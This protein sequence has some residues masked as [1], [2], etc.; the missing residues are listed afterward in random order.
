MMLLA[1]RLDRRLSAILAADV[2][3][4]SRL[5]GADEE[6]TLV[7]LRGHRNGV[8]EPKITEH[9]GRLVKT[10]GDGMLAEFASA[11]DAVRC[12]V[13][14]QLAT[15]SA[16]LSVASSK[17]VEFRIGVHVGDIISEDGDI[18]GD[19]VNIA[20]RLEGLA[21]PGGI[22]VS[23]RVQEDVDGRL[24]VTFR[25]G[26]EQQLKNIARP[27]RVY[28]I[29]F[30]RAET[31]AAPAPMLALPGKPSVVVLPFQN[32]SPDPDQDYF[33]D[34]MVED[35][36]M[37]LSRFS[38][39]FVISR[40][41]S[42]TYKG[43]AVDVKQI[44]REL[45]VRYVLEGSVRKAG[46]R[47]RISGQLVDAITGTH[48][49]VDRFEGT[50][51]DVFDLQDKVTSRVAG[52]LVPTIRHAEIERAKHRPTES[53]DAHMTYMRGIGSLYQW[54]KA[55]IE[56][57]LKLFHEAM[58][59]DPDFSMPY[60][61][62]AV[63]Y[64]TLR[65]TGWVGDL[66]SLVPRVHELVARA[67]EV[68]RDDAFTLGSC[69]FAAANILG[70]LDTG[71]ALLD[72]A[73]AMNVNHALMWAQSAYV[74][75]WRGEPELALAHTERARRLSP[76]DPQTFTID[77]AAALAHFIAGRDEEALAVAEMA[78]RQNPFFSPATRIA[79]ASAALLNRTE[80]TKKYLAQLKLLDPNLS[81]SNLDTRVGVR[82]PEDIARFGAG[83][84]KAGLPE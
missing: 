33:A 20:A 32:M 69:G 28:R 25:D 36:I 53:T 42:F 44:G 6:G 41:S 56:E 66:A 38:S 73:L 67:P 82:R 40:N 3:G 46:Q 24:D 37:A 70:D 51:E 84:R 61:M 54:T 34:G 72:R 2:A 11:V 19:G 58:R 80:L 76:V 26:G 45:G 60:G 17:R 47:V 68:G 27:I 16:N 57:A 7:Q 12:A 39:L 10:T 78:L 62:A 49:W 52:A 18:F 14:I 43:R 48:L 71:A 23:A 77:G 50:L 74:C 31:A 59:I 81:L 13:D 1:E 55:G 29:Q 63:S 35:I 22:C 9:R 83:L 4:Y 65:S 30:G 75:A 21:D 8:V 15:A 5:M 64:V 79:L